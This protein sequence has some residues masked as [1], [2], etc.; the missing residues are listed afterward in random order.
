MNRVAFSPARVRWIAGNTFREAVRQRLLLLLIMVAATMTGGALFFSDFH[1]G[2]SELKF[3]TDVG[4]GALA[5]FGAILSIVSSAQFFFDEIERRTVLTVLAKP[6]WRAEFV[7]GKL[8]GVLLLLLVFCGL[9][10]ALLAGLLWWRET[11]LMKAHPGT[12]ETGRVVA[13][14][15]VAWCGLVQWLKLSVLAALTLLVASY[16]R[17]SLLAIMAGFVALVIGQLQYL[18]R[19]FYGMMDSSLARG[20]VWL[21]GLLFP[22]FQL[23]D[24][25]DRVGAGET[26]SA[27]LIGGLAAYA[28]AYMSVYG[29][30]AVYCFRHR[31]L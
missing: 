27:G 9:V 19:D 22:N 17:S 24:V 2:S 26:L 18:A 13:Y 23:F 12:F 21:G 31:E 28:L 15:G 14:A 6:V 1:F 7:L 20:G 8:G 29:G 5:F 4:F 10:T 11:G 16:A 30:L 25:T 3:V